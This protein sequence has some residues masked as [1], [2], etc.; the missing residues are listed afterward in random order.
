[1]LIYQKSDQL[2]VIDYSNLDFVGCVDSG[3][4]TYDYLFLLAGGEI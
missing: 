3:K 1:M 4:S 2:E